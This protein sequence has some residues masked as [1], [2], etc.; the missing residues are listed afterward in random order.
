LEAR[1]QRHRH[2][3]PQRSWLDR[4]EAEKYGREHAYNYP[5]G[6][7]PYGIPANGQL[8]DMLDDSEL[9]KK[10][11]GGGLDKC[12]DNATNYRK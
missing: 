2:P 10:I 3:R 8:A 7:R 6:W 11:G 5:R 4:D 12:G 9:A 1:P